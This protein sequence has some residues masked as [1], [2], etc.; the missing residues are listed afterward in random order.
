MLINDLSNVKA[1]NGLLEEVCY[2]YLHVDNETLG[3]SSSRPTVQIFYEPI[4]NLFVSKFAHF[5]PLAKLAPFES[6]A[7]FE[8]N[9]YPTNATYNNG[10]YGCPEDNGQCMATWIH[11]SS[12]VA[13]L[14][15]ILN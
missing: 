1:Q 2:N 4:E 13:I 3:C 10:T 8:F 7:D 9:P 11:V 12:T 6:I 5:I 15:L 14:L